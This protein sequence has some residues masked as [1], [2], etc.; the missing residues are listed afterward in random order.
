MAIPRPTPTTP[1]G[2]WLDDWFKTHPAC[3]LAVFGAD[4]AKATGR[5]K[6]YTDGAVSQWISGKIRRPGAQALRGIAAVTKEPLT[7]LEILVYG[8]FASPAGPETGRTEA[9]ADGSIIDPE[10]AAVVRAAVLES[11]APLLQRLDR[12]LAALEEHPDG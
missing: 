6:P 7:N 10:L 5:T 8:R 11:M 4:V 1:F 9:A 3:T 2:A 12:L